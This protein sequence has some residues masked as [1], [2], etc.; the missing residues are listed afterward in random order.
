MTIW[1]P[2]LT[3]HRGPRYLAIADA[4]AFDIRASRLSPGDRLSTHRELAYQLGVTVGTVTRAYGEAERRGLIGGEVGRG[5]FVRSD[6]AVRASIRANAPVTSTI[7]AATAQPNV[8]DFSINTPTDLDAGGKYEG[9]MRATLRELSNSASAGPCS[10]T[11]PTA[12]TVH[13][14]KRAPSCSRNSA[15]GSIPTASS[16]LPARS[17]RSWWRWAR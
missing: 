16:L 8:I 17:T 11:S 12:A 2:D 15:C 9:M 3:S 4:L 5:T 1:I 7:A 6:I 10:T 14:A 13:I